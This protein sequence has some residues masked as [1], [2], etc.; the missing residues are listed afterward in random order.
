MESPF[1]WSLPG[2]AKTMD[3]VPPK[4]AE[5][6]AGL[7]GCTIGRRH[8][9][10]HHGESMDLVGKFHELDGNAAVLEPSSIIDALTA[11]R[12]VAGS[13]DECW[14]KSHQGW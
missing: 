12:I 7:S 1:G 14:R 6:G 10:G 9:P 4:V 3:I 13:E 11:Q 2:I 8:D 5:P